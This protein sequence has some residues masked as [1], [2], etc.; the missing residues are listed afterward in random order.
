MEVLNRFA[1]STWVLTIVTDPYCLHCW[2]LTHY[3]HLNV[4]VL[5][6]IMVLHTP[7]P[8]NLEDIKQCCVD[9]VK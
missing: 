5:F 4:H 7:P 6:E 1:K 3:K 2:C 9:V 8:Y